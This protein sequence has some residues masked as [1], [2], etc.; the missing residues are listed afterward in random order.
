MKSS[1]QQRLEM[2]LQAAANIVP[3]SFQ[4][5]C[6]RFASAV[7]CW[8][9]ASAGLAA[10]LIAAVV[11]RFSPLGLGISLLLALLVGLGVY[12]S[13]W[14]VLLWPQAWIQRFAPV[15]PPPINTTATTIVIYACRYPSAL[16]IVV[17]PLLADAVD[18][19]TIAAK[20]QALLRGDSLTEAL[21]A[22]IDD[23]VIA[24]LPQASQL[25]PQT[26]TS[27]LIILG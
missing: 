27:N 25:G 22:C 4:V 15:L 26:Q 17:P 7:W 8:R 16:V 14:S 24:A 2:A 21:I 6:A 20:H 13:R 3:L 23:C 5:V 12:R 1:Q 9:F 18:A 10:L 19:D 11:W